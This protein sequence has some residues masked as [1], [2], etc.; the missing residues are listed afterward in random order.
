[1]NVILIIVIV[2]IIKMMMIT[3]TI[4]ITITMMTMI[5]KAK[6]MMLA[7]AID[8]DNDR[9]DLSGPLRKHRLSSLSSAGSKD[10]VCWLRLVNFDPPFT[11]FHCNYD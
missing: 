11:S 9:V 7:V 1:M 6:I 3:I 8:N 2:T 5:M 10:H 4:T